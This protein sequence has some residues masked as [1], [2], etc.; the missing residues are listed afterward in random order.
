M[1]V[2][3]DIGAFGGELAQHIGFSGA[4]LSVPLRAAAAPGEQQQGEF[5]IRWLGQRARG[6]KKEAS[7]AVLMKETAVFKEAALLDRVGVFIGPGP[8]DAAAIIQHPKIAHAGN[9]TRLPAGTLF[10][11]LKHGLG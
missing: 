7:A 4:G 3:L 11:N 9:I 2:H 8:L 6:L 5:L 1:L 10:E